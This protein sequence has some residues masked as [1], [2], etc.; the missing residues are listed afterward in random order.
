MV[1]ITV[2]HGIVIFYLVD[3]AIQHLKE[4]GLGGKREC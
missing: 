4:R 2:I 1:S 3:S